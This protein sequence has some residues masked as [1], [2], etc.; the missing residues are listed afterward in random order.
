MCSS[1]QY[2][3][4]GLL[5]HSRIITVCWRIFPPSQFHL[6]KSSCGWLRHWRLS[7]KLTTQ[8]ML[9]LLGAT[10]C[11][12][13]CWQNQN[14]KLLACLPLFLQQNIIQYII[15]KE[16]CNI[17]ASCILLLVEWH[18]VNSGPQK[19]DVVRNQ[20]LSENGLSFHLCK[21]IADNAKE[22]H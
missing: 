7:Y 14:I 16:V 9:L 17:A 10:F 21:W 12:M 22:F 11:N 2:L 20:M 18:T 5:L 1:Q 6:L 8:C 19:S 13:I 3:L 15:L 4:Q